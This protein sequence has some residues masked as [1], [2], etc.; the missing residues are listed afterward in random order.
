[1]RRDQAFNPCHIYLFN[2]SKDRKCLIFANG[3][4]ETENVIAQLRQIAT[5]KGE[6]DIYHVHHGSI[7]AQLREAAENAMRDAPGPTVTAATVTF[8][9]GIDLGQLDRVIQL[10]SPGSV[11]SFLQRL[12]RSGRR[13]SPADMRFICQEEAPCVADELAQQIPWQLLQCI[14]I[15]QLYLEEKWIEPIAPVQYPFSLLYQQTLSILVSL[16]ELSPAALAQ[17]VLTLPPFCKITQEDFRLFLRQ[18]IA[19]DHIQKTKENGLIVGLAGEKI[20]GSFKFYAIFPDQQEYTVL[21]NGAA[22]GSIVQSPN[23]GDRFSLAG[24]TW[25]AAEV[26]SKL[27]RV[28]VQPSIGAST[29]SWRGSSGEIHTRILQRMQKVLMET[30]VYPYLQPGA[31]ARLQQARHLA[32]KYALDRNYLFPLE[33]NFCCIL[34]W[35]GTVAYRTLERYLRL[36]CRDALKFKGVYGRSPYYIVLNLG[37]CSVDALR[38]EIRSLADKRLKPE[39]LLK[40]EEA[41]KIQKYDEFIPESLLRKSFAQDQLNI[42]ELSRIVADW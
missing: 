15:I 23:V 34:P 22:I 40:P 27:H 31:R 14:A 6:A 35:A 17:Q 28:T 4:M 39:D 18:L 5:A 10:E 13:G 11:A 25:Q 12:G 33:D 42:S 8:E 7:S 1:M 26:N 30:T 3:R 19:L 36:H 16:G 29:L 9:M 21:F 32:Q 37:E 20:V 24:R 2:Q 41:P 38:Q